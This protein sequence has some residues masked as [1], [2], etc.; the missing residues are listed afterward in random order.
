M[1]TEQLTGSLTAIHGNV[2]S[3]EIVELE[4]GKRGVLLGT[5]SEGGSEV[6]I[7]LGVEDAHDIGL[8]LLMLA[9]D[10]AQHN[11]GESA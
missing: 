1:T 5:T 10:V 9:R 8:D 6:E 7:L 11:R 2:I 3:I 4:D